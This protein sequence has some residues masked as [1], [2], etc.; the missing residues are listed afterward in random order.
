[1]AVSDH[2]LSINKSKDHHKREHHFLSF[3]GSTIFSIRDSLMLWKKCEWRGKALIP[4]QETNDGDPFLH[5]DLLCGLCGAFASFAVKILA[6]I[7]K[8]NQTL[9]RKELP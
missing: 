7:C 6:I 8:A 1:V 9:I 2:A 3:V 4:N 5:R